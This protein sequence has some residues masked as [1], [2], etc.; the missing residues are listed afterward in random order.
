MGPS[1]LALAAVVALTVALGASWPTATA[2][3]T[4]PEARTGGATDTPIVHPTGADDLI[5]RIEAIG[6]LRPPEALVQDVPIFALYGDG[7]AIVPGGQPAIYPSP[8]L[9][10][11]RVT[12]VDE[13]GIQAVLHAADAAGLLAGDRHFFNENVMDAGTTVFT[14]VANGRTTI[15]SAYALGLGGAGGTANEIAAVAKLIEFQRLVGDLGAW[16]PSA[17]I[18]ERDAAYVPD[19]LQ[20]VSGPMPAAD[21]TDPSLEQR[22]IV[23]PLATPLAAFGTDYEPPS[24]FTL[25]LPFEDARCGVVAGNDARRLYSLLETANELTPWTSDSRSYALYPRPLLPDETGCPPTPAAASDG[26]GAS[27]KPTNSISFSAFVEVA[28]PGRI[29]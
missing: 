16:V 5:L 9:P 14:V 8:S 24:L 11:L 4:T 19:R 27:S 22:P 3:A 2:S 17:S 7:R 18:L 29:L 26:R 15:V 28:I 13:A 25:V 23:W 21:G 6:G 12:R 20:L 10:N 1:R